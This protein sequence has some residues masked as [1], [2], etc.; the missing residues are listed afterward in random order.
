MATEVEKCKCG[1]PIKTIM[2]PPF[3][4]ELT[5]EHVTHADEGDPFFCYTDDRT[6]EV[7]KCESSPGSVSL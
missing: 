4:D 2:M 3:M 7:T 6:D 5:F 1:R